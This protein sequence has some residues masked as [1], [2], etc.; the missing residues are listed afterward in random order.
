MRAGTISSHLP[1]AER[2]IVKRRIFAM[3][4][5]PGRALDAYRRRCGAFAVLLTVLSPVLGAQ[6][7]EDL[8]VVPLAQAAPPEVVEGSIGKIGDPVPNDGMFNS[9]T[10]T[11]PQGP[12]ATVALEVAGMT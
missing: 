1:V 7:Y 12:F 4:Q 9:Y 3:S 10:V 2:P 11:V 6:E 5:E 8:T